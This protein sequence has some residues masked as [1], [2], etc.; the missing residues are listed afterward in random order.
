[1]TV[2]KSLGKMVPLAAMLL[3]HGTYLKADA[4][5]ARAGRRGTQ[6]FFRVVG[7]QSNAPILPK[8][9]SVWT[10]DRQIRTGTTGMSDHGF[11]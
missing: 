4:A 2:Q 1:M 10:R 3:L 6:L 7:S 9:R 11:T 8:T 5:D